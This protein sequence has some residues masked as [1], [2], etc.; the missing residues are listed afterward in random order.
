MP[1]GHMIMLG[2]HRRQVGG[3]GVSITDLGLGGSPLGNRS[4]PIS[5]QQAADV[6][7]HAWDAGIRYFDT[8][9]LYGHGLAEARLGHGLRSKP[10]AEFVVS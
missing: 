8:A 5:D 4:R 7:Q 10:R 2:I 1:L 6:I 3:S 9:P